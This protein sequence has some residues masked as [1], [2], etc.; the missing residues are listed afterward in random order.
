MHSIFISGAAQ[1]IGAAV[2]SLF[3]H[4]DYKVGIYD[5]NIS[6]AEQL[7]EQLGP[8]AH[9]GYLDVASYA[10]WQTALEDFEAWAGKINIL[11]NNAGI[12]YSG[13]FEKTPH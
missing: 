8:N 12:L 5:L 7:A 6:L 3:C 10:S 1:G 11:V 13:N 9:A 4:E 2:A